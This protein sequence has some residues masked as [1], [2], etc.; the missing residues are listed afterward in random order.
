MITSPML[1][2]GRDGDHG[3]GQHGA[4]GWNGAHGEVLCGANQGLS[5]SLAQERRK[6][7]VV[8]GDR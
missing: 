8:Q 4:D 2:R 5:F 3:Y 6:S 1:D 7:A